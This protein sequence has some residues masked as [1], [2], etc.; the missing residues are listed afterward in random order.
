MIRSLSC[1]PAHAPAAVNMHTDF[2]GFTEFTPADH[3]T[4]ALART[5]DQL[6]AWAT[7]LAVLRTEP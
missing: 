2:T 4:D 5:L 1:W 6:I 3:Q 7:A